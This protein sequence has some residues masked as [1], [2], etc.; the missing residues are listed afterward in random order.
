MFWTRVRRVLAVTGKVAVF[1][2]RILLLILGR[3]GAVLM[4]IGSGMKGGHSA[5]EQAIALYLPP[6]DEY[7][8]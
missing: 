3:V 6:R 4:I 8:P 7:R 2:G 1:C 5:D